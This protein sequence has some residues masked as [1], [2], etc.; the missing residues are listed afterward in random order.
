MNNYRLSLDPMWSG[1]EHCRSCGIFQ[2]L[3]ITFIEDSLYGR[4]LPFNNGEARGKGGT[5]ALI[6]SVCLTNV[7]LGDVCIKIYINWRIQCKWNLNTE[8]AACMH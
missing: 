7:R 1:H 3:I 4:T 2:P 6:E 8:K 5:K